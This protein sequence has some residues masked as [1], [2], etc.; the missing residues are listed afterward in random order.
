MSLIAK[1]LNRLGFL[2]TNI[3]V[4]T[5]VN[6][7]VTLELL[8][9]VTASPIADAEIAIDQAAKGKNAPFVTP[10]GCT[11]SNG[12]MDATKAIKWSYPWHEWRMTPEAAAPP[13]MWVS[14]IT[15]GFSEK[16]EPFLIDNLSL[17]SGAYQLHLRM[18]T[19]SNRLGS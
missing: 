14:I 1:I 6:I 13:L 12:K 4:E 7:R 17:V 11:D 19:L 15:P 8:D 5:G 2:S 16:R 3:T 9:D 18:L 10:L